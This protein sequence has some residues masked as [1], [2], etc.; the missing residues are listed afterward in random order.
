MNRRLLSTSLLV[1][2]LLFDHIHSVNAGWF[3]RVFAPPGDSNEPDPADAA[4]SKANSSVGSAAQIGS[5][6]TIDDGLPFATLA[7]NNKI[8]LVGYGVGNLQTDLVP[9]MV[10]SAMQ[11]DKKTRLFD[12]AHASGN[13]ALVA[14]G[15]NKGIAKLNRDNRVEV[16][17]VTKVWYT[18]LGYERTRLSVEQSLKELQPALE[19]DQA[20]VKLHILIHWPRCQDAI[21]WMDCRREEDELPEEVKQAGPDPSDDPD[22]WK[23]SW[24]YLEDLYLSDKHPIAS[25]GISNFHLDEIEVMEDFSRI[26]PHVLQVNVWSLLYD[27]H[28]VEYCHKHRIHIQ[29]Y[30]AMHGTVSQPERA[31]RA[32]HHIQKV[33]GEISAEMKEE[34]TPAQVILAW[35]VQHGISVIPRT[36]NVIRLEENSAVVL[37]QIPVFSDHQVET[38]AH[39][40]EAYLS[41]DDLEKDI[42]VS[43]TFHV[44]SK[45]IVIYWLGHDG[46]ETRIGHLKVGETFTDTTYPNHTF[47]MYDAQNKDYWVDHVVDANF[48]DH[49]H[50]HVE[51]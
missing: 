5:A 8:P 4:P 2:I 44:V 36:S 34:L 10:M 17:V 32:F 46:D 24:K 20:D 37:S 22:A 41:G 48:G 30:N 16:H 42:H 47:R 1:A 25:I 43:V 3:S 19:N 15:I 40:V 35:L 50:I 18:H 39:S 33:A 12:T 9:G 31:P 14:K 45:D 29:A 26:H 27:S 51:L 38:I 21:P 49:K 28:L 13:E 11:D 23:E 6:I 7:N